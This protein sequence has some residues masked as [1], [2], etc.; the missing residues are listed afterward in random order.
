MTAPVTIG[1]LIVTLAVTAL[2]WHMSNRPVRIGRPRLLP[3]TV[4]YLFGGAL[5]LLLAVHLVNLAG[6]ETGRG[7][8]LW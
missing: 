2:A 1:L 4:I 8:R 6:I 7:R 5:A 3:W